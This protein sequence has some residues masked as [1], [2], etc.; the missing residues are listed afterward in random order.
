MRKSEFDRAFNE[1]LQQHPTLHKMLA[2]NF[3]CILERM[4]MENKER[5]LSERKEFG[6]LLRLALNEARIGDANERKK[7]ASLAG[8]IFSGRKRFAD[9]KLPVA[10]GRKNPAPPFDIQTNAKGQLEWK[11]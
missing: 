10:S 9:R 5:P 6:L 8:T 1:Q 3:M 4:H 2:W 11:L 7:Y